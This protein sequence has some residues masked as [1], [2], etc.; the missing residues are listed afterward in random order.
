M[1]GASHP[2]SSEVISLDVV[3]IAALSR[4][5]W[6]AVLDL[7]STAFGKDLRG[8]MESLPIVAHVFARRGGL[9][10]GHA[11]WVERTLYVGD[12]VPLHAAYIE[13]VA[14]CPTDQGQGIGSAV[15]Q[16]LASEI[17]AYELGALSPARPTFYARLGWETWRG[18]LAVRTSTG[19]VSTPEERVMIL[20]TPRTPPLDPAA[21][22][23][24]EWREGDIW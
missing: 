12:I 2:V 4:A 3:P 11:C 15:M 20:R 13:A 5:D 19:L 16:R 24:A 6:Q 22:L 23:T 21:L 18:P 14:T 8:V 17:A 9:L 1:A 7:C 10:I